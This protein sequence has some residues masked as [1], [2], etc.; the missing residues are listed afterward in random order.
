M[1]DSSATLFSG[2]SICA[3]LTTAAPHGTGNCLNW[4]SMSSGDYGV[5]VRLSGMW[6]TAPGDIGPW[7]ETSFSCNYTGPVWCVGDFYAVYLPMI[8]KNY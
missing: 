6:E 1:T 5:A 4:S 2:T 3:V 8:L 7:D